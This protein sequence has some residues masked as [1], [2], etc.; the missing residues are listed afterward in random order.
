MLESASFTD[1][2]PKA[3]PW[4][5]SLPAPAPELPGLGVGVGFSPRIPAG[6][7]L[8]V[9]ASVPRGGSSAASTSG[10]DGDEIGRKWYLY[11]PAPRMR[12]MDRATRSRDKY[13]PRSSNRLLIL[14]V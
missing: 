11:T 10:R 13:Q 8:S 2:L 9:L 4:L 1:P 3:P 5:P 12:T 7:R 6:N 14:G